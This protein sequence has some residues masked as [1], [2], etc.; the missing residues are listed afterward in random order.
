MPRPAFIWSPAYEMDIGRHVFPTQKF[1]LTKE[2][3]TDRGAIREEEV[4]LAPP[5]TEADLLRVLDPDYLKALREGRHV[6]ATR[7]SELPITRQIIEAK[8]VTSGGS[9]LGAQ[10]ALQRGAACHL[11]GGYHHAY[12][13]HAEGFCY[14]NDVAVAA[15]AMMAEGYARRIAIIDTDVHQG[16]GTAATFR[17][18]PG[19]FTFSI[20]EEDLYPRRKEQSDLDIGLP[21]RVGDEAYLEALEKGLG[22]AIGQFVP[23]LVIYAAGVDCFEEDQLGHL[24]LSREGLARRDR[25]VL[26]RA[27]A[28]GIPFLTVVS[29]GYARNVADTISLHAQTVEIAIDVAAEAAFGAL[30]LPRLAPDQGS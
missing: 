1:R 13:D 15:R 24:G 17:N 19:V 2:L 4:E 12:P 27:A 29:G 26:E 22:K 3:L 11:G 6:E 21:A 20:H 14:I 9:V 25:M 30:E 28:S 5:A 7:R 16:N 23:D 18:D 10:R 8:I